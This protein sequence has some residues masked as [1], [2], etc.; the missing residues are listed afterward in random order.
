MSIEETIKKQISENPI[1]IY[2]KGNPQFPQCGFSAAVIN[3]F[4]QL[5][6][7]YQTVDVLADPEIREGIKVF[8][9]W[10]TIPQVYIQGKFIGGC[11]IVREMHGR[12]ELKPLAEAASQSH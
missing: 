6:V 2:M 12:G 7:K 9:N 11:D 10:P 3:V 4:N 1:L 8:S 5:G